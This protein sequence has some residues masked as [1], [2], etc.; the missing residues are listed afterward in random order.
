[1]SKSKNYYFLCFD[2]NNSVALNYTQER[3]RANFFFPDLSIEGERK[4]RLRSHGAY[5][6]WQFPFRRN[7]FEQLRRDDP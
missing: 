2:S 3:I 1:M 7:L 4:S 5:H 6:Y